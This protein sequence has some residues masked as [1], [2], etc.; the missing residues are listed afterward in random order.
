MTSENKMNLI[1]F[2]G[3]WKLKLRKNKAIIFRKDKFNKI[4]FNKK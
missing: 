3:K 1:I 2:K 4:N